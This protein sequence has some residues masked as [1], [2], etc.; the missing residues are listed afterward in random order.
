MSPF[1]SYTRGRLDLFY[2]R[3]LSSSL[4]TTRCLLTALAI[5][6]GRCTAC[7]S[8]S[9]PCSLMC[10]R[11]RSHFGCCLLDNPDVAPQPGRWPC[12]NHTTNCSP[13]RGDLSLSHGQRSFNLQV[14]PYCTSLSSQRKILR[15]CPGDGLL[16]RRTFHSRSRYRL[17]FFC[18]VTMLTGS[19][20]LYKWYF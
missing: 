4:Q 9:P 18:T 6:T 12:Q 13:V 16:L 7:A 19:A 20:A 5:S 1:Q 3:T 10:C 2:F 8:C 15:T 11:Q 17:Y 14:F